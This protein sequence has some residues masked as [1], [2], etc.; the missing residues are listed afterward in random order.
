MGKENGGKTMS[1]LST[2]FMTALKDEALDD[3]EEEIDAKKKNAKKSRGRRKHRKSIDTTNASA[4]GIDASVDD[5]NGEGHTK[6][7]RRRSSF[8]PKSI[9]KRSSYAP[10]AKS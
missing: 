5:T 8:K 6:P 1:K 3:D 2:L 7:G 4:E 10:V 9:L